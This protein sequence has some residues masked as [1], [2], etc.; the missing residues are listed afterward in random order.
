VRLYQTNNIITQVDLKY[1]NIEN[2]LYVDPSFFEIFSFNLVRGDKTGVLSEPHSVVLTE[3]TARKVFGMEDPMDKM[4][5]FENDTTFFRVTGISQDPPENS[6]FEYD[7]LI[8]MDAFWDNKSDFWLRNNVNTYVLLL[9][10]FPPQNLE[11]KFPEMI[12]KYIGPQFQQTLGFSMTQ[13]IR[14]SI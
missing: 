13:P 10:G 8:S 3:S 5:R 9:N 1:F 4:I 12:K 6:H 14:I 2:A 7:M 11:D